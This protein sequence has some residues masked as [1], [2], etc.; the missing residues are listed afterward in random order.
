MNPLLPSR[1]SP[2]PPG[3]WWLLAI[4]AGLADPAAAATIIETWN[5]GFTG[6]GVVPDGNLVGWSDTRTLSGVT[7]TAIT[8]IT[9][10]LT[11]TG[12]FN[13]DLYAYL[14]H[15][16]GITIL[17]NRPGRTAANLFGY[18]DVGSD[19][20]FD[21]SGTNGDSHVTLTGA[22]IFSASSWEPDGRAVNPATALDTDLRT[23]LLGTFTGMDPNGTWTLFVADMSWDGEPPAT[24]TQ[25]GL[26]ITAI[27]AIPEPGSAFIQ[28][29]FLSSALLIRRRGKPGLGFRIWIGV[30]NFL[31]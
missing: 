13:G 12:G 29:V 23:N 30:E 28:V 2:S 22:S 17:L 18:S 16:T 11:I 6:G 7:S 8:V 21:D 31:K 4:L 27:P 15:D 19:V 5:S 1:N 10:N 26:Q 3:R 20:I 9:V 14:Q 25:W 24:V